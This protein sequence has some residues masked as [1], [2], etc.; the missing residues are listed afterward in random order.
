LKSQYGN[1]S[2]FG[3]IILVSTVLK[4]EQLWQDWREF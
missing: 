1:T 4:I 2:L 3:K